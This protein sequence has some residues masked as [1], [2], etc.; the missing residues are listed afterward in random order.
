MLSQVG[1]LAVR[2][3]N[4]ADNA[5]PMAAIIPIRS[6]ILRLDPSSS[7]LSS[8]HLILVRLCLEARAFSA[9]LP[10]IDLDIYHFPA[11]SNKAAENSLYP[12]LCSNHESSSTFF[13]PDSALSGKL[14]HWDCLQYFLYS[15]MIYMGLKDWKKAHHFLE[16]VLTYPVTNNAS[17]IQVEAYKKWVLV[18]L[19]YRGCV[20]RLWS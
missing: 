5:Q 20:S 8:S 1:I 13:T 19:L 7:T 6:A 11:T 4:E 2:R 18:S 9:A 16:I 12:F 15:A 14:N 3:S 17:K 10:V